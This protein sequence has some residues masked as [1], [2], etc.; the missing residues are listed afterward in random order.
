MTPTHT[1]I[2]PLCD[3]RV[4]SFRDATRCRD[5]MI[6]PCGACLALWFPDVVIAKRGPTYRIKLEGEAI[7]EA[8][9]EKEQGASPEVPAL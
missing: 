5:S 6:R 1:H 2:C 3:R 8:T 7:G 4:P 9:Q